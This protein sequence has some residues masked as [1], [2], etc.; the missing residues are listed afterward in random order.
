MT[1]NS[2]FQECCPFSEHRHYTTMLLDASVNGSKCILDW[3]SREELW[4]VL[5][6]LSREARKD[7]LKRA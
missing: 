1:Q 3:A 2:N 5:F 7:G 6:G 4:R